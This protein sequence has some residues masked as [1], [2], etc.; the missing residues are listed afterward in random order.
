MCRLSGKHLEN[1]VNL[2]DEV[3][4]LEISVLYK[5]IQKEIQCN[6]QIAL[7]VESHFC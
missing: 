7:L 1:L 2:S 6:E 4:E 5:E 3:L